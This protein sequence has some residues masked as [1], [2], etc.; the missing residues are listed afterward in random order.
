[1]WCFDWHEKQ[2]MDY[3]D[4]LMKAC[5][6]SRVPCRR[7]FVRGSLI[8]I[9]WHPTELSLGSPFDTHGTRVSSRTYVLLTVLGKYN[10]KFLIVRKIKKNSDNFEIHHRCMS[11]KLTKPLN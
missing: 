10:L 6:L 2:S 11:Y 7:Y 8:I 4:H 3:L 1:M 5:S 9:Y